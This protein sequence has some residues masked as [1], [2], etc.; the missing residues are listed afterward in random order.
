MRKR[1]Y[2]AQG[3]YVCIYID[4]YTYVSAMYICIY[5]YIHIGAKTCTSR[6]SYTCV[7][8]YK[9]IQVHIY[10]SAMYICIH[11]YN[12]NVCIYS[13]RCEDAHITR[14]K[15]RCHSSGSSMGTA[16]KKNSWEAPKRSTTKC[17]MGASLRGSNVRAFPICPRKITGDSPHRKMIGV[18]CRKEMRG[19]SRTTKSRICGLWR[20]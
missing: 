2:P 5:V 10:V 18:L 3:T 20:G 6:A 8:F 19:D 13:Y 17:Q 1:A 7:Y 16:H 14:K 11:V 15:T 9:C 12:N 4:V